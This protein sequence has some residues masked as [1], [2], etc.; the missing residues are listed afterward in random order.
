MSSFTKRNFSNTNGNLPSRKRWSIRSAAAGA[1]IFGLTTALVAPA[2]AASPTAK[3]PSWPNVTSLMPASMQAPATRSTTDLQARLRRKLPKRISKAPLG[4]NVTMRVEDLSTGKK[5]WARKSSRAQIPAS[6]MKLAT[7]LA[8]L[9]VRM[10]TYQLRTTVKRATGSRN[11]TLVGGGDPLLSSA[12][13]DELAK[14]TASAVKAQPLPERKLRLSYDASLFS[15]ASLP[16][17]WSSYYMGSYVA[18]PSALSRDRRK[19]SNPAQDAAIYFRD[20]LRV[21][22]LGKSVLRSKISSGISEAAATQVAV[23]DS[24]D[25]GDALWQMLRYSDNSVAELMIRHVALA[26]GEAT[27]SSGSAAA[28]RAELGRLDLPI[29]RVQIADGSGLSR[30]NR[31]PAKTLTGIVRASFTPDKTQLSS[32]YRNW[33]VPIAGRSG[34]LT[35]RFGTPATKCANGLVIAK[36]GT[37]NGVIS[38]S[39]IAVG[40]DGR[41]SAFSILVNDRP[42][43]HSVSQTRERVD[44]L[45]TTLTGCK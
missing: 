15:W 7:A 27:T 22:G 33:S 18:R 42:G 29:K 14:S 19:V 39:G 36:T 32:P 41:H 16:S 5:L 31:L 28:V 8:V 34:T 11:I 44:R 2:N 23:Y 3:I 25:V 38:L 40:Q 37:L 10:D 30:S 20:R 1:V 17:G 6:T 24:H 43:G 9:S 35:S 12:N 21:H 13:L 45:A 4:P 26:R